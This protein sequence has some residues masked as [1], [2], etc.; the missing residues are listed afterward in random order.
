MKLVLLQNTI[1]NSQRYV[2]GDVIDVKEE[3]A[4]RFCDNAMAHPLFAA[5]LEKVGISIDDDQIVEVEEI[6]QETSETAEND[7]ENEVEEIGQETD[8]DQASDQADVAKKGK[9]K[10][11]K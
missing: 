10:G 6:G 2:A 5:D 9:K 1:F 4:Q 3:V 11:K 8:G 7:G